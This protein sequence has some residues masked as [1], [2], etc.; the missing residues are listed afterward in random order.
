MGSSGRKRFFKDSKPNDIKAELRKEEQRTLNQAFD[1]NVAERLDKLLEAANQ[2]DT[3]AIQDA[4][5]EIK[6]ALATDIESTFDAKFGGSVRKR[7]FVDGISDIDVLVILKDPELRSSSP[8]EVLEYF[9]T[10]V[11]EHM[12]GW[13]VSRG[14]LALTLIR[15]GLEIQ[16]LP[17]VRE[18]GTTHIP[19]ARGNE[20]SDI[21]PEKFFRQLTDVNGKFGNKVVPVIKLAKIINSQ[22]P[23]PLQLSGY[24]LESLAVEAFR[25]YKGLL[26]P[27]A[28]LE[29]FFDRS[30]E[31]VLSPI[32]DSTGQSVHVDS[33]LGPAN[34]GN[35]RA[36]SAALDRVHRRM[37]NADASG[38]VDQ[39]LEPFGDE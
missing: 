2:R 27:K 11:R 12:K 37:R 5:E 33:D 9:E 18:N 15:Q 6:T 21:N 3:T 22:Q 24:H 4:I 32:K 30:R 7:T 16:I 17:A 38:S 31:L 26:N 36:V 34:S 25:S 10:Q 19:G 39:W 28:M 29:H 14:T 35:R 8:Q 20:W 23:A 13:E 1:A